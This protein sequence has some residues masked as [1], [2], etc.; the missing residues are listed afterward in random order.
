MS[1]QDLREQKKALSKDLNNQLDKPKDTVWSK[2]EQTAFDE[3]TDKLD[4]INAQIS[5]HEKMLADAGEANFDDAQRV[6]PKSKKSDAELG[7]NAFLRKQ[8]KDL[9]AEEASLIQNTMSTTTGSEGG[10]TVQPEIGST[11]IETIQDFGAMRRSSSQ[12]STSTGNDLSYPTTDGTSEEGEIV[13]QNAQSG[14]QDISFGT[15]ALNVFKFGSFVVTVPIELLQDSMIDVQSLVFGR[16]RQRIGRRQNRAFSVGTNV[17]EPFGLYS[18]AGVGKVGL[19]GQTATVTYD[20]LVDLVDSMDVAY[21]DGKAPEFMFG[22]P[23]RRAIRKIK[24]DNGRP[25]WTPSYDEGITTKHPDLLMGYA[26]QINNNAPAPGA[27]AKSIAF[28]DLSQYMVRDALDISLFK[29]E[30]SAYITKGQIGFMAWARS[31][32]NLLDT[33]AVKLYQHSAT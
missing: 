32:G 10:Y 15:V 25:I 28:G 31:G 27:D 33:N 17:D 12:I 3:G 19:T 21:L 11:L 4:R 18:A 1:I 14:S 24:D 30:D 26:V 6:D 8:T 7:L 9:S 20:D 16:V 22:Q 29:F 2:E 5:A 23:I 13:A